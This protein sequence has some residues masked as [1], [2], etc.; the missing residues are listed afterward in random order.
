MEGGAWKLIHVDEQ[1]RYAIFGGE[2]PGQAGTLLVY[3]SNGKLEE[4]ITPPPDLLPVES[5][6]ENHSFWE[7]DARGRVYLPV[8]DPQGFKVIRLSSE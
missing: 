3:S 6:L 4:R 5:T 7:V 2:E 8:L 1:E